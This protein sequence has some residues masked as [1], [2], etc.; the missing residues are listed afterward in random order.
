MNSNIELSSDRTQ[1]RIHHS[2]LHDEGLY[3]CVAINAAGNA[4]QQQ[5][6]YVGGQLPQNFHPIFIKLK[7]LKK[8]YLK[9]FQ[10]PYIIILIA[11][12]KTKCFFSK[13]EDFLLNNDM[14]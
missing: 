4:T 2:K 1:L 9:L 8:I 12:M 3:S 11:T 13:D 14:K 10:N 7:K 5:Q 6:L